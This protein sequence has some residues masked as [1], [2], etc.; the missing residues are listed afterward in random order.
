MEEVKAKKGCTDAESDGVNRERREE[1]KEESEGGGEEERAGRGSMGGK[2]WG[3]VG[4][5]NLMKY[6]DAVDH[7]TFFPQ[8]TRAMYTL[9][10]SFCDHCH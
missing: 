7:D 5:Q 9:Q 8:R 3:C 10:R 1:D 4:K 6:S 2:T